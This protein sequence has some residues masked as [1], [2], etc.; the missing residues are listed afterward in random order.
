VAIGL[1][2]RDLAKTREFMRAQAIRLA[3]DEP[4]RLIVEPDEALGSALIIY[5]AH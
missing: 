2:S 3:V 1:V 5:P 4:N